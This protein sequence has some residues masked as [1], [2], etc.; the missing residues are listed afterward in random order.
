MKFVSGWVWLVFSLAISLVI[1]SWAFFAEY[2]PRTI[3]AGRVNDYAEQ[4]QTEGNKL[5]RAKQKLADARKA[6][7]DKAMEW[8]AVVAE[9]TPGSS[10]SEGGIDLSVTP[11][12]LTVDARKFRDEV[13]RDVNRQIKTGGVT[14]ISGPTVPMPSDQPGEVMASFFNYPAARFP[15]CV[16]ELG[17]ITV[18]GTYDQISR[19]MASWS[20]MPN[21]LAVADGLQL[22]GTS[23][24]LTGTY[25]LV[26]V[27][28]MRGKDMPPAL[29]SGAAGAAAGM[30]G[31]PFGPGGSPFAPP[32]AGSAPVPGM[33]FTPPGVGAPT[34]PQVR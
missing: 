33:G 34:G 23:P 26:V 13:Q 25:N 9:K 5:G 29:P 4:L 24:S 10:L 17:S 30:G 12:Q 20:A 16:F 6:V 1:L 21:Y 7:Q 31:S 14:V 27:A 28:F 22:S 18:T 3:F 19:H 15:V 2:Q 11:Y 8:Q 32:G